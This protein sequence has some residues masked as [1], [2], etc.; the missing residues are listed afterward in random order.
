M[1][2]E[3][4]TI[5]L[6]AHN[7]EANVA[8][9]HAE[10]RNVLR[11]SPHPVEVIFVDDGSNDA[12]AS[13]VRELASGDRLVRLV[14]FSRNFGQQAALLAGLRAAGGAAVITMDCDLQHPPQYLPEMVR[15]WEQGA[16]IVQMVRRHTESTGWFKRATSRWFYRIIQVFSASPVVKHAADYQLLDREI[17]AHLLQFGD[18]QPFLRGLVSWLGFPAH[19]IEYTAPERRSGRSS[20]GLRRM[21]NL[22]LDA[23]TSLSSAPLRLAFYLGFSAAALGLLYM[24]F[25]VGA[26]FSGKSVQGWTSLVVAVVFLGGVQLVCIGIIGEYIARI[27]EHTRR[28]PPFIIAEEDAAAPPPAKSRGAGV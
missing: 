7:E 6:P 21:L 25:A 4:I 5:V 22:S 10:I 27:Y 3:L 15:A 8:A 28:V 13:R 26:Y 20:Y 1:R 9:I 11:S 23:I 14:R 12:T 24:I 2:R 17:V 19:L 16:K 18:R